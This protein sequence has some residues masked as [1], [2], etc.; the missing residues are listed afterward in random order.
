MVCTHNASIALNRAYLP[1]RSLRSSFKPAKTQIHSKP[2]SLSELARSDVRSVLTG[3]IGQRLQHTAAVD[4]H[5]PPDC[6]PN[7][8]LSKNARETLMCSGWTRTHSQIYEVGPS[9]LQAQVCIQIHN[10]TRT[11]F[12]GNDPGVRGTKGQLRGLR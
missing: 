10:C 9:H 7:S 11:C 12:I 8:V 3:R 2:L 1:C 4:N 5:F 6:P